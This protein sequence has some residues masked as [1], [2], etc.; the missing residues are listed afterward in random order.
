MYP[1]D[2]FP[3]VKQ[4]GPWERCTAKFTVVEY[5]VTILRCA[6]AQDDRG[7]PPAMAALQ[8]AALLDHL[9]RWA[10]RKGITCCL[11]STDKRRV[12]PWALGEQ[13]AVGGEGMCV[14]SETRVLVSF[15]GCLG[16]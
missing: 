1:S 6:P 11:T 14:G 8:T 7:R 3:V 9:D 5:A 16:C 12:R 10:V 4:V 13:L 15:P 2:N